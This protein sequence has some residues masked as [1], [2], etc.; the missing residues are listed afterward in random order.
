[1]QPMTIQEMSGRQARHTLDPL[2]KAIASALTA[3][4][5]NA[6]GEFSEMHTVLAK[7]EAQLRAALQ[8]CVQLQSQCAQL[9]TECARLRL[10][11]DTAHSLC[12]SLKE[13]RENATEELQKIKDNFPE[14]II[15]HYRLKSDHAVLQQE[16][17]MLRD[18]N[19][20]LKEKIRVQAHSGHSV[21]LDLP[22]VMPT[23]DH[24]HISVK[25]EPAYSPVI[26]RERQNTRDAHHAQ[27]AEGPSSSLD[28]DAEVAVGT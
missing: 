8:R 19:A 22:P 26:K 1:M 23:E 10:E 2:Y 25:D 5:H 21:L 16:A 13:Q 12:T 28:K 18:V 15:E 11:R 6:A 9:H 7:N 4:H 20:Q 27:N 14:L 3:V 24:K 17:A